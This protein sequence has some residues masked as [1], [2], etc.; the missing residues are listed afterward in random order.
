[1]D[2]IQQKQQE[3]YK[4]EE[5]EQH[6]NLYN[7]IPAGDGK[8]IVLLRNIAEASQAGHFD[9]NPSI[10]ISGIGAEALALAFANTV[11]SDDIRQCDARCFMGTKEMIYFYHESRFDSVHI[12]SNID[13]TSS[14]NIVWNFIKHKVYKF[15]LSFDGRLSEYVYLNGHLILTATD[16]KK[17]SQPIIDALDFKVVVDPYTEEQ[18]EMIIKQRLKF[19]GIRYDAEVITAML[20]YFCG[21]L[22]GIIE[23]LRICVLLASQEGKYKLTQEHVEKAVGMAFLPLES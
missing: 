16:I 21:G 22:K 6:V 19:C 12:I 11:C 15:S 20:E 1:M 8:S 14:D 18:L 17:V 10:L 7:F 3:Q 5:F 2:K 23:V 9:K 13:K 4:F